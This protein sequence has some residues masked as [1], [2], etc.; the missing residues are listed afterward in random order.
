MF[1]EGRVSRLDTDLICS[2]CRAHMVVTFA[3]CLRTG[4]PT[5]CDETMKLA[6]TTADIEGAGKKVPARLLQ[7]AV[8]S[9]NRAAGAGT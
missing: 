3:D 5:C 6:E 4:W 7:D 1:A 2:T 8:D 9:L